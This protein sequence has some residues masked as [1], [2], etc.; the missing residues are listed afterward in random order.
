M[1]WSF[2]GINTA[3]SGILAQQRAMDA[4]AHN[5]SNAQ[6]PGY[7]RQQAILAAAE[8]YPPPG[9]LANIGTGQYGTGVQVAMVRRAQDQFLDLHAR[10]LDAQLG[11]WTTT[12]STLQEVE[13]I[14]AQQTGNNPGSLLDKFWSAWQEVS[15]NPEDTAVRVTLRQDAVT[16]TSA[17]RDTVTQLRDSQAGIDREIES[18]VQEI[19]DKA[20]QIAGLN[21][22]I[23]AV[24]AEGNQPNDL[25]DRRDQL[26]SDLSTMVGATTL[27]STDG[28]VVVNIGGRALVEGVESFALQSPLGA[29]GHAQV[30]WAD[31]SAVK[32]TGGEL[33]GLIQVRDTTIP[34]YLSQLDSIATGLISRV[35][36]LHQA[37]YGLDGSTG[38]SFLSGTSAADIAVDSAILADPRAIAAAAS[39]SAPGDGSNALAIAQV[40]DEILIG[41]QTLGQAY[42][43]L[44][45]QVGSETGDARVRQESTQAARQQVTEQQQ[46]LYGVSLDEEMTNM[47][48]FQH[49]YNAAAR[50]LTTLDEMLK[51]IIEQM[52]AG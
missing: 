11:Q 48:Q 36:A 43:A 7:H 14:I 1:A 37:G 16:L 27:T 39:A 52:G 25:L 31:G 46:S 4:T 18:K 20:G 49:A 2:L 22:Q 42:N 12:S 23:T 30:Q 45:S 33:S 28:N 26:L 21:R 44:V 38:V 9:Q 34:G 47:L 8:P 5:I 19:N 40:R 17:F 32:I 51:T 41:S 29:D 3:L 50:V 15:I 10:L 24:L 35:N 13:G 6:T